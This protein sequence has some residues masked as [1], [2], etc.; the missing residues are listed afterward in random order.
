[1]IKKTTA[2][3][4][5][6]SV[7][8]IGAGAAGCAAPEPASP[9][10]PV[11]SATST[12]LDQLAPCEDLAALP[13]ARCGTVT[14]PL[15]RDDPEAGTTQVGF[16]VVPH[17]DTSQPGLGT[18]VPNPGGPG[19]STIDLAGALFAGG[20]EPL[21]DRRDLLL[22]D[23]RG[24]GRSQPL[25]CPALEGPG[26]VFADRA[27]QR[28]LIGRCGEELGARV[29]D[30]GTAAVADD[31]DAVRASLGVTGLDLVG[32]S[33]GTYLMPTYAQ[34]YPD[35]VRTIT[36]AGAYAVNVNPIGTGDVAAF[37]RAFGLVCERTGKCD[38]DRVLADLA[39]L[40]ARLRSAA[41]SVE[42]TH[43]GVA[44]TV[45]VDDW[46]MTSVAAGVF[47]GPADTDRALALAEAAAKARR[48]DLAPVRALVATAVTTSAEHSDMDA[49]LYS[50]T[51]SWAATCH[52]Y[53][54]TFDYGDS[55]ADRTAAYDAD[56]AGLAAA[57]FA[58]F[59]P[60]T[61]MTRADYDTGACLAWPDDE[62]AGSP[63]DV[64]APLPDVPVLVLNGDLDAN[65]YPDAGR[66]AA[67]QFP[68]A[69]FLEIPGAGHTPATT[70]EGLTA[71]LAFISQGHV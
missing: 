15:D 7:V 12:R 23:P 59:T 71:I 54:R 20:L 38:G 24:V 29:G 36:M 18:I 50:E 49:R 44:R 35:H 62:T 39:A 57:D 37:R 69:T 32:V 11:L 3:L 34:R 16:A 70:A 25:T 68:R 19:D 52:D 14:V 40:D 58:P 55:V 10:A 22:V 66:A 27:E 41:T 1:M 4:V 48:G 53:P 21:L 64:G 42:V 63:F 17:S 9:R 56:L 26:S 33:Y 46:R 43:A 65:T 28:R 8:V 2:A 60:Q 47:S 67:A 5:A 31:I 30:Y 6:L 45:V 13:T 61:W 51:L